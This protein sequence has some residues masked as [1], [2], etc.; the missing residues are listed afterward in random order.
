M[1][2]SYLNSITALAWKKDGSKVAAGSLCGGVEMF[3]SVLRRSVWKNKFEMTYVGPSQVRMA[4]FFWNRNHCLRQILSNWNLIICLYTL[5]GNF[6]FQL[7]FQFPLPVLWSLEVEIIFGLNIS[8]LSGRKCKEK[9]CPFE[10]LLRLRWEILNH[11][12]FQVRWCKTGSILIVICKP[13]IV[14]LSFYWNFP[15]NCMDSHLHLN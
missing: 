3:E 7:Q 5:K 12:I 11:F 10:H 6:D 8:Y 2:V 13:N 14:R 4:K 15:V 9:R 1:K